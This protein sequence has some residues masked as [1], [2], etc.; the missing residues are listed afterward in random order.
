MKTSGP[1]LDSVRPARARAVLLVNLGSP[2]SPSVP[3]VRRYLR[4][5]LGD[6]RVLDLP[7]PLRWLLL[8]GVILPTRPKKSA[9]AYASVWTPQGSPLMRI[10]ASVQRKLATAVGPDVPVYLAMRYGLPSLASVI[11]R[12]AAEG[13]REA[14]L[15]PQYPHYAMSSWETVVVR[16]REEA[17]RRN[18]GMVIDCVAPFYADPD[19]IAAL[20]AVS[21]PSLA[22]PHDHVLFSYHGIPVRHLRKADSSH[23]HCQCTA[24]CCTVASPAHATCYRAQVM[25][26]TRAFAARAGLVPGKYSVSFQSRL[27][28]EPWCEPFTDHELRR[29][30]ASGVKRLVVL[31]PAF[32]ADCLE[33]LEEIAA[34]GR[35]TFLAA[36]GERFAV[37]PCLN[38]HEAYIEFLHGRV[39]RW[40][41]ET[42]AGDGMA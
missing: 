31:C 42:A 35:E 7:A 36:G 12:M 13:I 19:Y 16:V 28:G 24:N 11:D 15:I 17:A 22:E 38:D 27:A 23:A 5:F 20:H 14:L 4:E 37:I 39:A 26:T 1:S 3:D 8:E 41:E 6:E 32:V 29:L 25:A 9:H 21:R 34:A 10:S 40:L 33:T 30:P 2:A 18:P